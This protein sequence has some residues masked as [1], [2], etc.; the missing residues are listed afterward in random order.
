MIKADNL[1][2][3]YGNIA[4]VDDVSFAVEKGDDLWIAWAEWSW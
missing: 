3:R 4:A 2:K 1:Q